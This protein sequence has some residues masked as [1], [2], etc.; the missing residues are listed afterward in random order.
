MILADGLTLPFA[1]IVDWERL[2]IRVPERVIH[3]YEK[4]EV[5]KG[6]EEL[7]GILR[8]KWVKVKK[9]YNGGW[10]GVRRDLLNIADKV[11]GGAKD[12]DKNTESLLISLSVEAEKR[13]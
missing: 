13:R 10:T 6:L 2:V 5:G 1:Q 12:E 9:E 3:D 4:G 11:F 7:I 8:E